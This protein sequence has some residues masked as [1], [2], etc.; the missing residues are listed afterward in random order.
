MTKDMDYRAKVAGNATKEFNNFCGTEIEKT[1]EEI[2]NDYYQIHFYNELK[3]FLSAD[4]ETH[5]LDA[6]SFRCLYQEGKSVIACLYDY[7]SKDEYAS[8][9][10]WE[11][12]SD[13]IQRYNENYHK[14]ILEEE[15]ELE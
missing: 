7:Y 4:G 8:T 6:N 13:F 15:T 11:E 1:K 14:D 9:H 3:E 10:N 12:I 2:F 5:Y